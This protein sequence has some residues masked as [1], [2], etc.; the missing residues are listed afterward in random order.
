[1]ASWTAFRRRLAFRITFPLPEVEEREKLWRAMLPTQAA[2]AENLDFKALADRYV[3]SGGYIRNA[4]LRAAYLAA[5]DGSPITQH[6]LQ[7]AAVLEYTAMGKIIQ[8]HSS[9]L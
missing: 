9:S 4:V 3:M 2:I 8:S 6:H 5:A 1:M 7:R